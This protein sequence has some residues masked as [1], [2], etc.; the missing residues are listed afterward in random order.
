[1]IVIKNLMNGGLHK[2]C[3]KLN[4]FVKNYANLSE[5]WKNEWMAEL[6][7]NLG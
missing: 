6:K 2:I 1:M 4:T 7:F 3:K 5:N